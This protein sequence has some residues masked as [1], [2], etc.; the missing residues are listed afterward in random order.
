MHTRLCSTPNSFLTLGLNSVANWNTPN[1]SLSITKPRTPTPKLIRT[2]YGTMNCKGVSEKL[3]V[4]C[5]GWERA[6]TDREESSAQVSCELYTLGTEMHILI[7][8]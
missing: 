2:A 6:G 8:A 3:E 1:P 4:R 5:A 7:C